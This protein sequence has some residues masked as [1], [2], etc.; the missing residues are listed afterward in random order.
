MLT[1]DSKID[2]PVIRAIIAWITKRMLIYVIGETIRRCFKIT[3]KKNFRQ[4]KQIESKLGFS[5]AIMQNKGDD[6]SVA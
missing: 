5:I 6:N 2:G 1:N 4:N 3:K